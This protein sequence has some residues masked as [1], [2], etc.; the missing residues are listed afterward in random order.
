MTDFELLRR[1]IDDSGMTMVAISEKTG[2]SRET[3]YNR[4]KGVGEF[5]ASEMLAIS[6]VLHLSNADRDSIFFA[7]KVESKATVDV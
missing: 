5:T 6:D 2:I 4:F 7:R 3:I 1:K